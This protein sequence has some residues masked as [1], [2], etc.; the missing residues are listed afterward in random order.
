MHQFETIIKDP[1]KLVKDIIGFLVPITVDGTFIFSFYDIPI[2]HWAQISSLSFPCEIIVDLEDSFKYK[3]LPKELDHL[4]VSG[5]KLVLSYP[6]QFEQVL[7]APVDIQD[8]AIVIDGDLSDTKRLGQAL[9]VLKVF[10]KDLSK[11][12]DYTFTFWVHAFD[13]AHTP[14]A[15]GGA[16]F[17]IDLD[18]LT[19]VLMVEIDDDRTHLVQLTQHPVKKELEKALGISLNL[20][21]HAKAVMHRLQSEGKI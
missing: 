7:R 2:E 9:D 16:T 18:G 21:R 14:P 5:D 15:G 13:E 20:S 11:L 1:I 6:F 19:P 8:V 3:K 12:S 4:F 10:E 17:A